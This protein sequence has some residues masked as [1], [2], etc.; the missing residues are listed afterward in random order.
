MNWTLIA[1]LFAGVVLID[2]VI[3][4]MMGRGPLAWWRNRNK[5]PGTYFPG[6]G[7]D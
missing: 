2:V 3:L 7:T 5:V 1:I 6:D 4:S